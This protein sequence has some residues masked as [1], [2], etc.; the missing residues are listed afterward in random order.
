MAHF[1]LV[2]GA[3]HGA[4]CWAHAARELEHLGHTAAA[5][6]LPGAGARAGERATFDDRAGVLAAEIR[7]GSVVVGHSA[8]G[9]DITAAAA[10]AGARIARLVYLA[11]LLP[12]ERSGAGGWL[13]D[14]SRDV[15]ETAERIARPGRGGSVSPPAWPDALHLFY[16]DLPHAAAWAAWRQLLPLPESYVTDAA[17]AVRVPPPDIPRTYIR[18]A[19]DEAVSLDLAEDAAQRLGV[20]PVVMEGSH[21]PFLARPGALARELDR[22]V[23]AN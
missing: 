5:V 4:W 17:P 22:A 21:S 13:A 3:F 15:G 8:G 20:G 10:I 12:P 23:R 7:P 19:N 16:G 1:V 2:H 18:C 9:V 14:A 11:A 6:D